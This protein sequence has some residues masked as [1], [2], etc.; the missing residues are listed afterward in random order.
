VVTCSARPAR[1]ALSAWSHDH[2][3]TPSLS[4]DSRHPAGLGGAA[5]AW[6]FRAGGHALVALQPV[7]LGHGGH[8]DVQVGSRP[9]GRRGAQPNR[10]TMVPAPT[11]Q[12][13]SSCSCSSASSCRAAAGR[14][15]K[16]GCQVRPEV[17]GPQHL[18]L[19]QLGWQVWR[20]QLPPPP[21][22]RWLL[23]QC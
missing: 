7:W 6:T 15:P 20:P 4:S 8:E 10:L 19:A 11:R 1:S 16:G 22:L 18:H 17:A 2:L 5:A 3:R 14:T 12:P 23:L 9:A 21:A 13:T